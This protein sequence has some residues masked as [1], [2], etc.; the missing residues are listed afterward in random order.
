MS[1]VV[2][3]LLVAQLYRFDFTP[4]TTPQYAGDSFEVAIIARD[5][6]GGIYDYNRAAFLSTNRGASYIYPNVIGPF[7]NGVWN[8]KV[9]ITLADSLQIRCTDDSG[10]VTS[11]SNIFQVISGPPRRLVAV[12]AGQ[13]FSPGTRDGRL[14]QP[15][16]QTAGDSFS[17]TVYLTDGWCNPVRYRID[18]VYFNA[19]DN[20][21]LLPP[22]GE[23]NDG[24]GRFTAVFRRAGAQHLYCWPAA[25]LP[26]KP[27]TSSLFYVNPGAFDR[28]LLVLP[29]ETPLPGDTA[30][31]DWMTPGKSGEPLSQYVREVFNV[32]VYPCDRCWNI[33]GASGV[34]VRLNSEFP[35]E[36]FPPETTVV[37]SVNF[38]VQFDVAN[39]NQNLWVVDVEGSYESYR[40]RLDIKARGRSLV[41][42][43]PDT[44][45]AGETA[46]IRV[47]VRDANE[48][49]I[50]AAV[51]RFSVVK[52]NG[53]VLDEAVLTDTLGV[54]VGRFLC[55][56]AYFA[57]FDTIVIISGSAESL[58]GIYVDIPDST[59]MSGK[60]MA[61]PNPFGFNRDAAEIVYYLN[62]SGAVAVQIFD[63]F[64]NEVIGWTFSQGEAGARAGI[65]RLM[66]NGRNRQGRRVASGVYV[67]QIVGQLH[68]GTVFRS[69]YR[70]GVVW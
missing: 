10:R 33:V 36:F 60:I 26:F 66:W 5:P 20:F 16:N 38:R 8:G 68:T 64:G 41:I 27:D 53:E 4:I 12:L 42:T 43:A 2:G 58:V 19:S 44:V 14:G 30:S 55:T 28:L 6:Y 62:R 35:I 34:R 21:A 46:H 11:G 50:T 57:E 69:S 25:G 56:R 63:P 51:C 23:I 52:G 13:Q 61:F 1:A 45:V 9:M 59:V 17:F 32:S 22:G 18:S 67:V 39:P 3:L 70:L 49:P 31:S 29:G 40:S 15:D 47:A 48:H 7:R 24:S 65:N 37:D 54:A